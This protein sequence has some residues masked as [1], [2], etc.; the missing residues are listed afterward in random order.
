MPKYSNSNVGIGIY[1][2]MTCSVKICHKWFK[3]EQ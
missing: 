2:L 3:Y 1:L